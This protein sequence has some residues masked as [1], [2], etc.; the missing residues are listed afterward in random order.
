[1]I[2]PY[3]NNGQLTV[4][5]HRKSFY[6]ALSSKIQPIERAFGLLKGKFKILNYM[7]IQDLELACQILPDMSP[8][9]LN[10]FQHSTQTQDSKKFIC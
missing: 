10:E 8:Q 5:A 9:N 6:V 4:S 1:M 7:D 3:N 2:T